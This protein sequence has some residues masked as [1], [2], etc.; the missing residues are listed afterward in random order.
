M[1]I[2]KLEEYYGHLGSATALPTGQFWAVGSVQW[3]VQ[4]ALHC[5]AH[6]FQWAG[7]LG[8]AVLGSHGQFVGSFLCSFFGYFYGKFWKILNLVRFS[9][10]K[11]PPLSFLFI[12]ANKKYRFHQSSSQVLKK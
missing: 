1:S 3:A 12:L 4:P 11:S 6:K 9:C 5:T 7:R 8:S 2:E 10:V